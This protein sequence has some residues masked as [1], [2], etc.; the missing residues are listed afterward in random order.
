MS[1]KSILK[2]INKVVEKEGHVKL[3]RY[4]KFGHLSIDVTDIFIEKDNTKIKYSVNGAGKNAS[5]SD[6][7]EVVLELIEKEI[8]SNKYL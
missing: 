6:I 3:T 4:I 2:A 1:E 7:N 8:K 5:L